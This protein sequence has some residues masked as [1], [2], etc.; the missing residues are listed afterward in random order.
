MTRQRKALPL[1]AFL[2]FLSSC[3]SRPQGVIILCAGDSL[4]D[5]EYPRHLHR[6]LG[7]E[8]R[9][10]KVLNYG[11]KGSTSGE[12]LRFLQDQQS[13]LAEKHPDFVLLQ[14]GTNDV[15]VDG[16]FATAG[17]FGRNLGEIITVFGRFTN[18]RGERTQILLA[19]IPPLPETLAFPFGPQSR[20]RVV[21][22]I[23]PVIRRLAAERQL[24]LVDNFSLF[25]RFPELLPD[26]HPTSEGYRRLAENWHEALEPLLD[27]K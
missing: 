24:A 8:G 11:R 25:L 21:A 1:L 26:V 15:R 4:T 10:S 16:D 17:E 27:K 14:L 23:N 12:Y 22:E 9:S 20:E 5:S 3:I 7:R 18:R 6:L 13:V 19:T 2:F